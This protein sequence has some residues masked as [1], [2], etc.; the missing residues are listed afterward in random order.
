[1]GFCQATV[2]GPVINCYGE[3][4][5]VSFI[6][7]PFNPFLPINIALKCLE[8]LKRKKVILEP[9][10]PCYVFPYMVCSTVSRLVLVFKNRV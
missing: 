10:F 6:V 4:I 2:G 7:C 3:V 1:M 5:G 9:D 8:D